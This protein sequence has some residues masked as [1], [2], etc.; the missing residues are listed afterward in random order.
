MLRFYFDLYDDLSSIPDEHGEV[1]ATLGEA[2]EQ[3]VAIVLDVLSEAHAFRPAR[4]GCR[5][6]GEHGE[7][8]CDV[9]VTLEV[10][11]QQPSPAA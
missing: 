4:H 8:F 1:F 7:A 6:R 10:I 11:A 5:I 3:A 2:R 9:R